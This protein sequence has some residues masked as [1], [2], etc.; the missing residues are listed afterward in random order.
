MARIF[1]HGLEIGRIKTLK[2]EKIFFANGKILINRGN[3]WKVW[4]KVKKGFSMVDLYNRSKA[5]QKE[6]FNA[7]PKHKAFYDEIIGKPIKNRYYILE[8]LE[9]K[10]DFDHYLNLVKYMHEFKAIDSRKFYT[11]EML[12]GELI[13]EQKELKNLVK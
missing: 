12:Y 9:Q 6:W 8:T 11:L 7:R 13:A 5:S 3:G 2:F 1:V 4:G 10:Q